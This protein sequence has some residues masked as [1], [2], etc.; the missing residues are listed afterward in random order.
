MII[1]CH[2]REPE[3][4]NRRIH[5]AARAEFGFE[6]ARDLECTAEV[7]GDVFAEDE[8]ARIAAHLLA[9]RLADGGD[10]R[11]L[12]PFGGLVRAGEA[13]IRNAGDL[14]LHR[15]QVLYRP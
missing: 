3:L 2:A 15:R 13:E 11:Q 1:D 9:E 4:G 12:P 10:V 8:H 5:H 14:L 6:A 7:A